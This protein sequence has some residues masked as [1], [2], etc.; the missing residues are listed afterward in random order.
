[1][2]KEVILNNKRFK[3]IIQDDFEKEIK[4]ILLEAEEC[5]FEMLST[6]D[7]STEIDVQ[8]DC[9]AMITFFNNMIE[10]VKCLE[11][12]VRVQSKKANGTFRKGG[13]NTLYNAKSTA[14]LYEEEYC[15]KTYA[16]KTKAISDTELT[17]KVDREKNTW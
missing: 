7:A 15:H 2:E 8:A 9:N 5:N 4:D 11:E 10:D 1:M 3:V 12:V 16:I 17:V 6:E 14:V 13:V